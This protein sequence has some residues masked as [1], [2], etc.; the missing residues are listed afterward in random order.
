MT[1]NEKL[2]L[3]FPLV[4]YGDVDGLLGRD[5]AELDCLKDKDGNLWW[6]GNVTVGNDRDGNEIPY[7]VTAHGL[8]NEQG[9]VTTEKLWLTVESCDDMSS[10]KVISGIRILECV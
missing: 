1:F 2:V 10:F 3:M 9:N 4:H 8:M 6:S 5:Y 7:V